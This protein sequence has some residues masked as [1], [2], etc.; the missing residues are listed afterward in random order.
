VLPLARDSSPKASPTLLAR[1][2]SKEEPRPVEEGKQ[3]DGRPLKTR[4]V[5]ERTKRDVV[6]TF[7]LG[8]SD[9]IWTWG[10]NK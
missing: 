5:N 7:T 1:W 9:T 4:T 6:W 3:L 10:G 8:A 2:M